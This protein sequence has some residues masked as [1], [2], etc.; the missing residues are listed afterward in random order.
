MS[1]SANTTD[2]MSNPQLFQQVTFTPLGS[3]RHS[4]SIKGPVQEN[5]SPPITLNGDFTHQYCSSAGRLGR[6]LGFAT[7]LVS[8]IVSYEVF[9]VSGFSRD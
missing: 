5:K 9:H 3:V 8:F 6:P 2:G 4:T 7:P 1:A